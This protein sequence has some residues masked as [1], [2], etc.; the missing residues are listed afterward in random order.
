MSNL[1]NFFIGSDEINSKT[2]YI[3]AEIGNNHNGCFNR[4]IEM[5]DLAVEA[6]ANA[7][8]FQMRNLDEVYRKRSLGK[9]GEDLGTEYIVD[10]LNRFELKVDA[11]F[12]AE[13]KSLIFFENFIEDATNRILLSS[14]DS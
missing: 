6:G 12:L 9:D 8:K 4:A 2:V 10:L 11:N 5:I 14:E 3:I 7:V 13:D 1:S